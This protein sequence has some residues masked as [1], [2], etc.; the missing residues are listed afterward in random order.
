[1]VDAYSS[2]VLAF[3]SDDRNPLDVAA[4]G[5]I[6]HIIEMGLA[7]GMNPEHLFRAASFGAARAYGF[8]DRGVVAPGFL[9]DIVLVRQRTSGAWIGGFDIVHVVKRGKRVVASELSSYADSLG[10]QGRPQTNRRNINMPALAVDKFRIVASGSR[11][12][13]KVKCRVIGVIHKKIVTENLVCE[14]KVQENLEIAVDVARDI[15]KILVIERHHKTGNVGKGFVQGFSLKQGAIALSIGHDS[16]NITAVGCSDSALMAAVDAVK[17]CD[18]GIV[19]VDGT[20]RLLASL[21]LP[22]AGLM[23]DASPIAVAESLKALKAAARQI[24]CIVEEPFLQLSFLSL[25]VI[26]ALKLTDKGLVDVNKF[27]FVPLV[28]S[29]ST[30]APLVEQ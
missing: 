10:K 19:V 15:L 20:G 8:L 21:E 28:V 7:N 29:E 24:G 18:G 23:T 1:L 2:A 4:E 16:H 6:D 9:A 3:C 17:K 30:V 25:P 27:D 22:I 11:A 14:M 13:D 5:H 26:P 12:G